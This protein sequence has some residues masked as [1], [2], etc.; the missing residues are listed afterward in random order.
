MSDRK[1][2]CPACGNSRT[3]VMQTFSFSDMIMRR[4][5]C[6]VCG[7]NHKTLETRLDSSEAWKKINNIISNAKS[8]ILS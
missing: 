6:L 3:I 2:E 7:Y 1:Y 4:R 5:K 8:I